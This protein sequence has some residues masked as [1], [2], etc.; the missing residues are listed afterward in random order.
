[1]ANGNDDRAGFGT[2]WNEDGDHQNE[3]YHR[4]GGQQDS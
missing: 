3:S 1:M 2:Y 4:S